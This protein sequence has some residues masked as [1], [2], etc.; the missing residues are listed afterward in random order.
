MLFIY[1]FNSCLSDAGSDVSA[2][3]VQYWTPLHLAVEAGHMEVAKVLLEAD[4][5]LDIETKDGYSVLSLAERRG[6]EE[7][8]QLLVQKNLEKLSVSDDSTINERMLMMENSGEASSSGR[9]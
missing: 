1:L 7:L 9:K 3:N 5:K 2:G 6:D 4:A 8:L